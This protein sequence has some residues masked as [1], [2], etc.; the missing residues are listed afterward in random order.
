MDIEAVCFDPRGEVD[1]V[2]SL[3]AD[4]ARLKQLHL[5]GLVGDA[6]PDLLVGDPNRLRQVLI[7]LVGNAIKVSRIANSVLKLGIGAQLDVGL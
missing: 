7:N 4:K 2:L 3:F 1:D 6:V 5:A